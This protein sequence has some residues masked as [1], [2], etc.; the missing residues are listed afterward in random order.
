MDIK[1]YQ[2]T[3]ERAGVVF[4]I[5][6]SAK[7]VQKIE[8][9][10]LFIFPADYCE[11]LMNALPVSNNFV[12]WRNADENQNIEMLN[13]PYEGIC[14]DIE[15]NGF[16]L[17]TWGQKPDKLED[18]LLIAKNAIEQAPIL[19]PILGHRYIPSKPE[20]IGN[21]IFS[22]YQTD[23]IYY[24]RDL[25]EYLENEFGYYFFG[26]GRYQVTEPVTRIPFWS[27][28]VDLNNN[29]VGE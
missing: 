11:F 25:G 24:G 4:E 12:D 9:H 27:Y 19:I 26:K 2:S 23:I 21:P 3:L 16:W 5:G 7:E 28:L 20:E 29:M 6:L 18:S 22:V 1:R 15:H 8:E 10:Y 17:R 13:W 14:F